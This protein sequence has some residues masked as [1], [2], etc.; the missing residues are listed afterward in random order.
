MLIEL[1]DPRE[2]L[3]AAQAAK[4]PFPRVPF[5]V[6]VELLQTVENLLA[7]VARVRQ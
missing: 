3:V 2:Q 7:D 1:G 4:Q 5:H 6:T